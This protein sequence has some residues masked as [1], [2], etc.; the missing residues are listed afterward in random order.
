[1]I[2]IAIGVAAV[3]AA[4]AGLLGLGLVPLWV[5]ALVAGVLALAT[6]VPRT[7]A[8]AL[9]IGGFLALELGLLMLTPLIGVGMTVPHVAVFVVVSGAS[10]VALRRASVGSVMGG[11]GGPM[12]AFAPFVGAGL[13]LAT[14]ALSQVLP[15]A[16]R[17]AW[18]MNGDTVNAM[19][20]SRF[21]LDAGGIDQVAVPQ[22]TPLPFG[23]AAANMESGRAGLPDAALLEH[24]VARTA[25]VW[26]LLIALICVLV[27]VVVARAARGASRAWAVS[28]TAVASAAPLIWYV[29][30]VQFEFGF[31][32]SSFAMVLLLAAWLAY[33]GGRSQP[34]LALVGLFVVA[35]GLLA[36]WS[37][38]VI[39]VAPLGLVLLVARW[40]EL[41]Q[42]PAR[43]LLAAALAPVAFLAYAVLVTVPT[44][45]AQSEALGSDGG[46]PEI[47]DSQILVIIAATVLAIV[48]AWQRLGGDAPRGALAVLIGFSIGLGYLLLQ[49]QGA[50]F[51]W[52]YYPAK[53]AWTTSILLLTIAAS[54]V[55]AVI[56]DSSSRGRARAV[57]TVAAGAALA[58]LMWGPVPH[59]AVAAAA[60]PHRDRVRQ[61]ERR[62]RHRVRALGRRERPGHAVAHERRRP[63]AE[64]VAAPGGRAG[65]RDQ[66]RAHLRVRAAAERPAGVRGGGRPARHHDPHL[67]PGR[68][69][70][71]RR[72]VPRRRL[73]GR[74]G[75]VLRSA[76]PG[77]RPGARTRRRP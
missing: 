31:M 47:T 45:L 40:R 3:L 34:V 18:A 35:L 48:V 22:P 71:P 70:G 32:N 9:G 10:A 63:L 51:G 12:L 65:C 52:G 72:D 20:F 68:R 23:M 27:G 26:V 37:P 49:R 73:L 53:F 43:V 11:P 1:M 50:V 57:L 55:V 4:A 59:R 46:F 41:R 25:Q 8:L 29:V 44:F 28:V 67:G 13:F 21:M 66:P 5:V 38:L 74:G 7:L 69:G 36:V 14:M 30:G 33:L 75:L 15:G 56:A 6:R 61:P 24:D 2:A 16:L 42:T 64:L 77:G 19:L 39:C 54:F 58:S 62:R 76:T 60:H 17:L